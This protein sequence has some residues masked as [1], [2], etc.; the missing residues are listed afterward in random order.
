MINLC[1]NR[2]TLRTKDA[3]SR[4]TFL[5]WLAL[6]YRLYEYHPSEKEIIGRFITR[7]PFPREVFQQLTDRIEDRTFFLSI[8]SSDLY[9]LYLEGNIYLLGTWYKVLL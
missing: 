8:V 6:S 1:F 7:T 5:R 2:F 4:Q 3:K 9:T